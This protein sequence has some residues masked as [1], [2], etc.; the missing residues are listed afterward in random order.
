MPPYCS[1]GAH[2]PDYVH[3]LVL[4]CYY[5]YAVA[6]LLAMMSHDADC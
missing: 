1:E 2:A 3:V 5:Y 4:A 6:L